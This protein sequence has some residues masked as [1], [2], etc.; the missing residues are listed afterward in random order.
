MFGL[1]FWLSTAA[2]TALWAVFGGE[3]GWG[4]CALIAVRVAMLVGTLLALNDAATLLQQR[5]LYRK[6]TPAVRIGDY[7]LDFAMLV[8]L[9]WIAQH[10]ARLGLPALLLYLASLFLWEICSSILEPKR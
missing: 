7:V 10:G 3:W 8:V 1:I 6:P 2:F 9:G 4:V 5:L